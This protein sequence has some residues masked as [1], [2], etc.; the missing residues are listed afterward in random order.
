MR[1]LGSRTAHD[2]G[3]LEDAALTAQA[4]T[5]LVVLGLVGIIDPPRTEVRDAVATCRHR[6]HPPGDDHRRPSAHR[7]G[8]RHRARHRHHDRVLTGVDLDRLTDAEFDE[9]A[10]SVSVF[11][12]VSPEHKLRIVERCN[13]RA[14]SSR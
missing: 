2:D 9:A 1:V 5:E 13:A 14:T 6:G 8:D 10:A 7:Q 12:R 4:E 3:G 11:A